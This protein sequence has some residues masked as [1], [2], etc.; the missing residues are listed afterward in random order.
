M[1]AV[2]VRCLAPVIRPGSVAHS[3]EHQL[4][5]ECRSA[6]AREYVL[7]SSRP[8]APRRPWCQASWARI[9][10]GFFIGVGIRAVLHWLGWWR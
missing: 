5:P 1:R 6:V 9:L 10:G 7:H 2:C 4:C 8:I 3:K